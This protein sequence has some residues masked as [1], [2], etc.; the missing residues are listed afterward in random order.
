MAAFMQIDENKD[1]EI[2]SEEFC[3]FLL[4]PSPGSV[5]AGEESKQASTPPEEPA[6]REEKGTGD[7]AS[8]A[9]AE[10]TPGEEA[11]ATAGAHAETP[12]STQPVAQD[13]ATAPATENAAAASGAAADDAAATAD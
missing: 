6:K 1:G 7:S 11:P 5:G 9:A 2:S 12:P 4:G 13:V 3:Q 10:A 8:P